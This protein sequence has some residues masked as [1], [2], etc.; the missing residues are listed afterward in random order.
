MMTDGD[1]V[2][3]VTVV[4]VLLLDHCQLPAVQLITSRRIVLKSKGGIT[5]IT[6]MIYMVLN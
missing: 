4:F 2:A 5:S 1:T 3:P 6:S